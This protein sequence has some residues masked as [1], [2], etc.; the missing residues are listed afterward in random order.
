LDGPVEV[1][2]VYLTS[3]RLEICAAELGSKMHADVLDRVGFD[4][5]V[6]AHMLAIL[7]LTRLRLRPT[8]YIV[9]PGQGLAD[10]VKWLRLSN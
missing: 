4:D 1:S 3:D 7:S 6:S 10:R 5:P 9:V 2:H 8:R